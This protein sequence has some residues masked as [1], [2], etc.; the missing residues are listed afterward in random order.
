MSR[1]PLHTYNILLA[2]ADVRLGNV[3]R[4][5]LQTMGFA[6]ITLTR[7][8]E[9][10]LALLKAKPFD[11]LVTEWQLQRI[12]GL[13]LISRIRR[14][15]GVPDPALPVILLSGRGELNDVITARDQGMNEYVRKPFSAQTLYQRLE[16]L[17]EKPR[18]F[19]VSQ[20]FVGPDRRFQGKPPQ[21][22]PERRAFRIPPHARPSKTD[23]R[24]APDAP[25]QVWVADDTLQKKLGQGTSLS[26]L[27]SPA[28]LAEAQA[29]INSISTESLL[30]I[31]ENL[32]ELSQLYDTLRQGENLYT[33]LP[34]QMSEIALTISSRAGMSGYSAAAK[35]AYMLHK[36][37]FT[38][39]RMEHKNHH[40]IT[41]KHMD[42]LKVTLKNA[43]EHQSPDSANAAVIHELKLLTDKLAA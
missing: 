24:L 11:F 21:G 13:E 18:P 23:T 2:D 27:I 4:Q 31:Q 25:A 34:I 32:E 22:V 41:E 35:V 38:Q 15:G 1:T 26:S 5:M 12:S 14:S 42:A 20:H 30:W 33:M 7:N 3:L 10:A 36:F 16:R 43:I 28:A 29:T 39:L 40:I 8:G 17:I 6:N 9:E 37:C 19:V